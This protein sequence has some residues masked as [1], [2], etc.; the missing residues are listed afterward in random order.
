[1]GGM[2]LHQPGVGDATPTATGHQARVAALRDQLA[3]RPPG[4]PVRLAKPTSNL[5]RPR[6]AATDGLDVS[7]FRHVLEVDP[8]TRT[9][10]VEGMVTYE[11]LVDATL[12]HGLMPLVVPQLKTITLG[13]AVTGLGIESSSFRNGMPH[14][15]VLELEILTGA[16]EI[17]VARPD[18]EHGDLFFGFP[19]SYGTLGYALR[20]RIELEPVRPY[21][22]LRHVRHTD[23]GEY[24]AELERACSGGDVDF[25]DGTV[26]G[27]RELYLTLG[28]FTD[29][30]P[31]PSDYTWLDIYYKSIRQRT[32]DHLYTRD[33]LW[34][35]DT[36]WF[37]CSRAL[38][39]QNRLV[40]LLVGPKLLRSDTYWKIIA[41][42]R[43]H[44]LTARLNRALGK[45]PPEAVVQD[46]EVPVDRAAEFLDFFRREIPISPVWICP[47]KQRD[48]R[49]W[50]LYELDPDTLYVNFGFWATVP[51]KPG[52]DVAAHNR[53]IE[54]TVT[55]LGGRKS[56]YSESFYE[57]EE[58]W[59]LY[60][61]PAYRAL[62]QR[63]DPQ[64]KL[65]DLY[66]KCVRAR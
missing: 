51:A 49:R 8:H 39:V 61:G 33:Y 18:N 48:R 14:E 42:E 55:E 13:G 28:T 24:F 3:A 44:R 36:D 25:V 32:T 30:A 29:E 52:Q 54:R 56:L 59:R 19:N 50:P 1:M 7:G 22:R 16:G 43:R 6:G 20:L 65:L 35:W 64:R 4:A 38:G 58:F 46:I 66:D 27:P 31:R 10:D 5:F 62:K 63:Y 23:P 53:L 17:V 60:N 12:P 34:R 37:W 41:F 9:A 21:V 11:Q 45:P 57:P 2:A 40:R 26:F 47:V 15:S